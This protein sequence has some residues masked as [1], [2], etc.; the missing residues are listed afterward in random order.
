MGCGRSSAATRP[1]VKSQHSIQ[2][3]KVPSETEVEADFGPSPSCA[4]YASGKPPPNP[5]MQLYMRVVSDGD[6]ASGLRPQVCVGGTTT[7]GQVEGEFAEKTWTRFFSEGGEASWRELLA[8][9]GVALSCRKGRKKQGDANQDNAFVCR[10]RDLTIAGIADGHGEAGHWASHWAARYAAHLALVEVSVPDDGSPEL[11]DDMALRRMFNLVHEALCLRAKTDGFDLDMSGTTLTLCFVRHEAREVLVAWVGDSRCVL[12]RG[13][14][15]EACALSEDHK[16]DKVEERVRIVSFPGSIIHTTGC[17]RVSTQR[18]EEECGSDAGLALSRALGD[19]TLHS[20]GIIHLPGVRRM[21]LSE[22]DGES[23]V[24]LCSDGVWDMLSPEEVAT[25]V[26]EAGRENV[27]SATEAIV[28]K[29]RE[30]WLADVG[31][32]ADTDDISIS[33]V[34]V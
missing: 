29:A 16:P 8:N 31:S 15:L 25:E 32:E 13:G 14:G 17:P 2:V 1:V 30:R 34:W 19:L 22:E 21:T 23:V 9:S 6:V 20:V 10:H 12:G 33:A 7:A 3:Y 24:L 18:L 5:A 28:A 27:A 26:S 4:S 11:P